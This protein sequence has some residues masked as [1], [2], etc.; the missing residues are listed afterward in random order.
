MENVRTKCIIFGEALRIRVKNFKQ[1]L[2][3]N[4]SKSTKLGITACKFSKFFRVACPQTPL[5]LF[6]FL[7]QLQISFA[8]KNYAC[9]RSRIYGFPFLKFLATQL[10]VT[11]G[12]AEEKYSRSVAAREYFKQVGYMIRKAGQ[13]KYS[14]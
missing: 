3:E 1:N 10:D 6:L 7:N 9:R 14:L 12:K 11:W 13:N 8:E 4:Y 5:E 2:R